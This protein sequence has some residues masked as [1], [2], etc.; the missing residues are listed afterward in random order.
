MAAMAPLSGLALKLF[1][2]V[3]RTDR[4]HRRYT[5]AL[6]SVAILLAIIWAALFATLY[7]G[8]SADGLGSGLFDEATGWD[9]S[10]DTLFVWVTILTEVTLGAALASRLDR[11]ARIY[12]PDF[13]H[14]NP[15]SVTLQQGIDDNVKH[16]AQLT[17]DIAKYRGDLAV[18]QNALML[19]T[20]M[21]LLALESRGAR[22]DN[23]AFI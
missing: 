4:G 2:N 22:I 11:I 15:E 19:Q 7:H 13:W 14:R 20:G 23:S 3:F 21:A 16:V 6:F 5:F 12:S 9:E 18:Y 10:K 17:G 1:G 8:L